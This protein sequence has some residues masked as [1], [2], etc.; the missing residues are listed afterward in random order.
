MRGFGPMQPN[1]YPKGGPLARS[2]AERL[3]AYAGLDAGTGRS[4]I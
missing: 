3:C 1:I 2:A 4:R